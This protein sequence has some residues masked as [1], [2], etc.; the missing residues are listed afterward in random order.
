LLDT[1]NHC[2]A[3]IFKND[4]I[5]SVVPWAANHAEAIQQLMGADFWPYGVEANR[6]TIEIFLRY[7]FEQ[8]LT[9]KQLKAD[10]LFPR[11]TLETFY[12]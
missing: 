1:K 11:E 4:A 8:G 7:S 12:V 9:A 5:H 6:K 2:I 3:A 10:E